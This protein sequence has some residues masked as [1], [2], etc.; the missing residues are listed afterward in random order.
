LNALFE[1]NK[2]LWRDSP[3]YYVYLLN[4][5]LT[6]LRA[7]GKYDNMGFFLDRLQG[8]SPASGTLGSYIQYSL[9]QHRLAALIDVGRFA[10][11]LGLVQA[12]EKE[13]LRK[14]T[15]SFAVR[16]T[17]YFQTAQVFFGLAQYHPA[18]QY[19]HAVLN[20]REHYGSHPLY[21]QC[22]LLHLLIH[23]ELGNADYLSYEVRSVER[24]LKAEK[25]L[26]EV[27]KAVL[28]LLRQL[29]RKRPPKGIYKKFISRFALIAQDPAGRQTLRVLH[30]MPW[31]KSK[32]ES[33]TFPESIRE[34]YEVASSQL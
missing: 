19:I 20:A 5:I 8:V 21:V 24:K 3:L 6:D 25:K 26:Y 17:L 28:E 10:E 33:K 30:L 11:A 9:Y 2:S 29:I 7:I 31:L 12:Y 1:Q 27:E 14:L 18:L 16:A 32:A 13:G 22:R 4:G 34:E 23:L 15:V